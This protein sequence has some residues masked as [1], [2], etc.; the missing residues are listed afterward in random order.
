MA[1]STANRPYLTV[2]AVGGGFIAGSSDTAG[3]Y[4]AYK[5]SDPIATVSTTA[6]YFTDGFKMGMR[7]GDVLALV[8][9]SGSTPAALHHLLIT[10]VT[11]AGASASVVGSS[12]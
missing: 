9:T 1:Y 4:W 11:T 10:H 3:Q 5:S 7:R 6:P 8:V 2:A 12:A